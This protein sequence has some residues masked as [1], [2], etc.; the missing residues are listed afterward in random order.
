MQVAPTRILGTGVLFVAAAGWGEMYPAVG[1]LLARLWRRE[2]FR[3]RFL[4]GTP[5]VAGGV[6]AARQPE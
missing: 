3:E 2:S 5:P 6:L 4:T 1:A